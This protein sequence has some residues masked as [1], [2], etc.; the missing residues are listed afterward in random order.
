MYQ[1]RDTLTKIEFKVFLE[2]LSFNILT[3][4]DPRVGRGALH[5]YPHFSIGGLVKKINYK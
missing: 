1:K 3:K 5:C 4:H 2:Y